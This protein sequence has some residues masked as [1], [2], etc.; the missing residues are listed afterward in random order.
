MDNRKESINHPGHQQQY[1]TEVFK[2][3]YINA[4]LA[5]KSASDKRDST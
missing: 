5:T 4:C 1:Q 2:G 3:A